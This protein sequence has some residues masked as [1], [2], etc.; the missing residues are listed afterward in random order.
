MSDWHDSAQM[1]AVRSRLHRILSQDDVTSVSP[2]AFVI[3]QS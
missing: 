3:L 1:G 2:M